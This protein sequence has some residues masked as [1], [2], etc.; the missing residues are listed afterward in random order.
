[1]KA[2]MSF[3]L[4]LVVILLAVSPL[5][6]QLATSGAEVAATGPSAGRNLMLTPAP[7]SGE[8]YA[9]GFASET[10]ANYLRGGLVFSSAYDDGVTVGGNGQPVSDASFS[11]WPTISLDQTRSRYHWALSYSPGFTFYQKTSS[12]NEAD[13]NLALDSKFRLSPHVTLSLR[14]SFQKAS[15][16]LNQPNSDLSQPVSGAVFVPNDSVIAP[17][18]DMFRNTANATL[19]YQFAANRMIG[20][21][22]TFT[23]LHYPNQAQVPGLYDSSSRG[24]SAF[25][26]YRLSKMHYVGATYQYQMFLAYPTI[27]QSET[28]AH[29]IYLFYTLYLKPTFSISL[30][31]G[32]QHSD[33]T[34]FGMPA[35]RSW[36]PAGGASMGWQGSVTTLAASYSRAISDGGGLAGAVYANNA[37]GALRRQLTRTLSASMG[38]SYASNIVLAALP[39]FNTGGHTI[40]GNASVQRQIG[41]HLNLQLQYMRLHQSYSDIAVLSNAPNRNRESITISYQ[42]ARPLG[43]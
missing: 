28:Q 16:V 37:T 24:G 1:M 8:G 25:Y 39:M 41:E 7:I 31:G 15:N 3:R 23:N 30:F 29:S 27:G 17:L 21:S 6:A 14:D 32:P 19:T 34:Q 35:S 20:A 11:M 2:N 36:S 10:R 26:N 42:F 5:R 4:N 40:S 38:A 9:M 12:R 22:G 13:Q 18:A 33:T 43:R